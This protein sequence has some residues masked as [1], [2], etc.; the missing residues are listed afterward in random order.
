MLLVFP[1]AGFQSE[2]GF[3]RDAEDLG[4]GLPCAPHPRGCFFM[5]MYKK[6]RIQMIVKNEPF[7]ETTERS[8]NFINVH[9][10]YK[11]KRI[12]GPLDC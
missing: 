10:G 3:Q 12:S 8:Q 1:C 2:K 7:F 6:Y 11:P 5:I 4:L 9:L